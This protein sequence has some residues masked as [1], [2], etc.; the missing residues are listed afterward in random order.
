MSLP[1]NLRMGPVSLTVADLDRSIAF[2]QSIVGLQLLNNAGGQAILGAGSRTLLRLHEQ[3]GI[4]P[5]GR[6]TGLFHFALLLPTRRDL[7]LVF[8]HLVSQNIRLGASNHLVS[9]ALYLSDP[10]GHG[11]EI[12]ADRPRAEWPYDGLGQI[13]MATYRLDTANLLAEVSPQNKWSGLPDGTVMGHVHLQVADIPVAQKFYVEQL[14]FD[15]MVDYGR[16]AS[17]VSAGGYH[18]HLGMNVWNS[19]QAPP[20]PADVAHLTDLSLLFVDELS[21]SQVI[22]R[23]QAQEIAVKTDQDDFVVQDPFQ[24]N[25]RLV[26]EAPSAG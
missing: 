23:L 11:I 12:Y 16:E 3:P 18:H 9:E 7:A 4:R 5:A 21:R 19:F 8:R 1:A 10:D 24:N 2:Y 25:L 20:P 15:H 17:F 14:G 13:Q 6:Y 22:A 26:I